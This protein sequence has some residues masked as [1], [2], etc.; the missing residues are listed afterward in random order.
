MIFYKN[1]HT[2]LTCVYKN[3]NQ[4]FSLLKVLRTEQEKYGEKCY[5]KTDCTF[6]EG[7]RE[8]SC[9]FFEGF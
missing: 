8:V 7:F 2:G 5:I 1:I 3:V 4:L 6:F 9:T